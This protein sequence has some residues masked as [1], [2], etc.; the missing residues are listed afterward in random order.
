MLQTMQ[1]KVPPFLQP[2]HWLSSWVRQVWV[3]PFRWGGDIKR[4]T[5]VTLPQ[6]CPGLGQV[7]SQCHRGDREYLS[8]Q[9]SSSKQ[10]SAS[11]PSMSHTT[12]P[13]T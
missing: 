12:H 6:I 7:G 3:A 1:D 10:V 9:V 8:F 2:W 11:I 13:I 4:R 5:L